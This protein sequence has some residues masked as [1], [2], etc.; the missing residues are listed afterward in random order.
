VRTLDAAIVI[1]A[2]FGLSVVAAI[3]L[4]R[5]SSKT[6]T[7]YTSPALRDLLEKDLIPR[8]RAAGGMPIEPIYTTA[9][10]QYNRLRVYGDDPEADFFLHASPL[11]VQ[12]GYEDGYFRPINVSGIE[13]NETFQGASADRGV[14]WVAFAWTPVVE[15]YRPGLPAV[16]DLATAE[17]RFGLPHPRLS[18]NGVYSV[19]L[20]EMVDREAGKWGIDRTVVQPVN[21]RTNIGGVA[22][23]TFDVTLGYEAVTRFYQKQG[24]KVAYGPPNFH[25]EN[26]TTPV[27]VTAGIVRGTHEADTR[28]F[29]DF[30]FTNETQSHLAKYYFRSVLGPE[31]D[32]EAAFPEENH[33]R[34]VHFDWADWRK[35]DEAMPRYEVTR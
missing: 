19:I 10:E 24:A 16:P 8:F 29:V 34:V 23:G 31:S 5:I 4:Q 9:G 13:L 21:A 11:Y 35:L 6:L 22:D 3:D 28:R 30:L 1:V 12:R 20:Y 27:L 25:G 15:V 32:D 26:V 18:N 17:L 14:T 7:V 2:I 33:V